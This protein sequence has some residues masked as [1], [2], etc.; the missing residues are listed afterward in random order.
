MKPFALAAL[1][2]CTTALGVSMVLLAMFLL[3]I[4]SRGLVALILTVLGLVILKVLIGLL[5]RG[6]AVQPAAVKR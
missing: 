1:C 2:I 6:L 5:S 4:M 3:E